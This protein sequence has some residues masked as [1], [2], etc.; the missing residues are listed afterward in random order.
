MLQILKEVQRVFS[1]LVGNNF[2]FQG[3]ISLCTDM[4]VLLLFFIGIVWKPIT[5]FQTMMKRFITGNS[6]YKSTP[7]FTT[8]HDR[9]FKVAPT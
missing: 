6:Y 2:G 7:W 3:H 1:V 9:I 4:E 8:F 5:G